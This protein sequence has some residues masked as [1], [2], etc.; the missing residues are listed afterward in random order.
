MEPCKERLFFANGLLDFL[1]GLLH[2]AL[3]HLYAGSRFL[4]LRRN[5][6]VVELDLR[7]RAGR[8]HGK[9]ASVIHNE[10]QHVGGRDVLIAV[11]IV[12]GF[13]KLQGSEFP[14]RIAAETV[15]DA[16]HAG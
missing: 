15:H 14:G 12:D 2:R 6:I 3:H 1:Y 10:F 13:H 7:F 16:S 5:R 11:Y 9:P 4:P 8:T